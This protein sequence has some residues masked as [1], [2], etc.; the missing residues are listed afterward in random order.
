M[1]KGDKKV[2]TNKERLYL[3][4][5]Y[6]LNGFAISTLASIFGVDKSS[7]RHQLHKFGIPKPKR[8]DVYAVEFIIA[9]IIRKHQ[10]S[11]WD[12][13]EGVRVNAGSNYADY[14]KRLSPLR[15]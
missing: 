15:K 1:T 6:R 9:P 4:V 8:G 13:I 7:I 5:N 14:L 3:L 10:P 12:I 2:F 11:E